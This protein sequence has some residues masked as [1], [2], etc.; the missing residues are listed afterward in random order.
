MNI[1]EFLKYFAD[2]EELIIDA[3]EQTIQRP[4]DKKNQ[5]QYYFA[6]VTFARGQSIP[7]TAKSGDAIIM[8]F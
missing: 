6:N 5:K 3:T 1:N 8:I 2:T 7:C 4:S